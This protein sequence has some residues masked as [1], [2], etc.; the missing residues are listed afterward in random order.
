MDIDQEVDSL[1]REMFRFVFDSTRGEL[2]S[3]EFD[4]RVKDLNIKIVRIAITALSVDRQ[5]ILSEFGLSKKFSKE[6]LKGLETHLALST[7]PV[8]PLFN[9]N[10]NEEEM[11]YCLA[12]AN[13]RLH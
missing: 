3:N 4:D 5:D 9:I 12:K 7:T 1:K 10:I 6:D 2:D 8:E 11:N 13:G